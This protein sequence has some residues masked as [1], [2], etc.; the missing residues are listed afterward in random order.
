MSGVQGQ[1]RRVPDEQCPMRTR[2]VV[3]FANYQS[4]SENESYQ[5]VRR[6][7]GSPGMVD[8]SPLLVRVAP[9]N[10]SLAE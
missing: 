7:I 3:R 6:L 5:Y 10:F 9:A 2:T 8:N 1:R 4:T